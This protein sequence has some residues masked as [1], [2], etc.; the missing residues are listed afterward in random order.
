[1]SFLIITC[2]VCA[3]PSLL[4][5]VRIVNKKELNIID[6]IVFYIIYFEFEILGKSFVEFRPF[7]KCVNL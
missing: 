1:M 2:L 3:L 6:F 4:P 7:E 5:V